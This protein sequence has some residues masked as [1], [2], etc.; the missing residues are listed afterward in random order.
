MFLDLD[1]LRG[2]VRL[3]RLE[4]LRY[5]PPNVHWFIEDVCLKYTL[6]GGIIGSN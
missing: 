2:N 6:L 4:A 1:H 3:D 5:Y